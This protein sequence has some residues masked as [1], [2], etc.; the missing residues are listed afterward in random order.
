[1]LAFKLYNR[2]WKYASIG[3]LISIFNASTISLA[4]IIAMIQ[5][6]HLPGLP[7]SIYIM[8]WLMV[9][10]LIGIS[11]L[12]WR[13]FRDYNLKNHPSGQRVLIVGAGDAGALLV[14]EIQSNPDLGL[15]AVAFVDDDPSK[16]DKMMLG[17]PIQ[18]SRREIP[19]LV[20]KLKVD[21]IIIAM[22]SVGGGIV[23]EII[24]ICKQTSV[25]L[26]ILPNIYHSSNGANMIANIRDIQMEDLLGR[27]AVQIDILQIS[28]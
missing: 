18:G 9:N 2:L 1:M 12:W 27:A 7:R 4:V 11:R 14:R 8:G 15:E 20:E 3:E 5:V 16:K 22:P 13:L 17:L 26:K 19:R 24:D 23:R 6:F 21:E 10:L 28:S 25:S